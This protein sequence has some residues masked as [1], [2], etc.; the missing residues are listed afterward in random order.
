M[1][2]PAFGLGA[3]GP[4]IVRSGCSGP[5]VAARLPAFTVEPLAMTLAAAGFVGSQAFAVVAA[6]AGLA[7]E[8]ASLPDCSPLECY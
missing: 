1:K 6:S 3:G 4:E 7:A 2:D 8:V 5:A